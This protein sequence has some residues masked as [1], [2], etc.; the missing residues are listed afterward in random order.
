MGGVVGESRPSHESQSGDKVRIQFRG[1]RPIIDFFFV[2]PVRPAA[3]R[4]V[5]TRAG[6]R[7]RAL[8]VALLAG[9]L[10]AAACTPVSRAAPAPLHGGNQGGGS[11][12]QGNECNEMAVAQ[13]FRRVVSPS[14]GVSFCVPQGF[15]ARVDEDGEVWAADRRAGAS[16]VIVERVEAVGGGQP[17]SAIERLADSRQLPLRHHS[18]VD[19]YEV[20]RFGVSWLRAGSVLVSVEA[21]VVSGGFQHFQHLQAWQ[22]TL[23]AS[24][25]R[26]CPVVVQLMYSTRN[27][28]DSTWIVQSIASIRQPE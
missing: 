10:G 24:R 8:R 18:C 17:V 12:P 9:A 23:C 15:E 3:A 22:A 6:S 7:T 27:S 21:L 14:V 25:V 4:D 20:E 13:G 5:G 16:R 11:E 28:S 1:N 26:E 19:C 2:P